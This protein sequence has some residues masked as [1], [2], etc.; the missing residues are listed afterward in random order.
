VILGNSIWR[1]V[2]QT[3]TIPG[4]SVSWEYWTA[5]VAWKERWGRHQEYTV[6]EIVYMASGFYRC[7]KESPAGVIPEDSPRWEKIGVHGNSFPPWMQHPTAFTVDI[8]ISTAAIIN[9]SIGA[10]TWEVAPKYLGCETLPIEREHRTVQ[11]AYAGHTGITKVYIA[12]MVHYG[13]CAHPKLHDDPNPPR[14]KFIGL[15]VAAY[16]VPPERGRGVCKVATDG[17][18]VIDFN[19]LLPVMSPST[20][21]PLALIY[22]QWWAAEMPYIMQSI[23]ESPSFKRSILMFSNPEPHTEYTKCFQDSIALAN[24]GHTIDTSTDAFKRL[25]IN[26]CIRTGKPIPRG[27]MS[28]EYTMWRTGKIAERGETLAAAEKLGE[29]A[30]TKWLD[31]MWSLRQFTATFLAQ[32]DRIA[33]DR[34]GVERWIEDGPKVCPE[35][36]INWTYKVGG[37]PASTSLKWVRADIADVELHWR[38]MKCGIGGLMTFYLRGI[39]QLHVTIQAKLSAYKFAAITKKKKSRK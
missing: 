13:E 4:K 17:P 33:Q 28:V 35:T 8:D 6:A 16:M 2:E 12:T 18:V 3:R 21:K 36:G 26:E 1:C 30:N 23:S 20:G 19:D 11:S 9:P 5:T 38:W 15:S 34:Y 7:I 29:V 24:H 10:V 22:L 39:E 31:W 37:A 32:C 27:N 14:Q 25:L